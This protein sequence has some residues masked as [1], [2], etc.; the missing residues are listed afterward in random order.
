MTAIKGFIGGHNEAYSRAVSKAVCINL[1][2]EVSASDSDTTA[3]AL[4]KIPGTTSI[5]TWDA[6]GFSGEANAGCRGSYVT[7]RGVQYSCLGDLIL[8]YPDIDSAP[9][10]VANIP[11]DTTPVN[12]AE[13]GIYLAIAD[14]NALYIVELST[15]ATSTPSLPTYV[16]PTHIAFLGGRLVINSKTAVGIGSIGVAPVDSK[17]YYSAVYDATKWLSDGAGSKAVVSSSDP[18]VAIVAINDQILA[19]GSNSV[20]FLGLTDSETIPLER[21]SG[22]TNGSGCLARYSPL[23]IGQS[24]YFVGVQANGMVQVYRTNGYAIEPISDPSIEWILSQGDASDAVGWTY[25]QQGHTFYG[26]NSQNL[27]LTL[28]YDITTGAWHKRSTRVGDNDK[29]W[30][31]TSFT[32]LN[33][34]V[35]AFSKSDALVYRI[36]LDL[37]KEH[38][39]YIYWQRGTGILQDELNGIV[40]NRITLHMETGTGDSAEPTEKDP[41]VSLSWSDDANVNFTATDTENIGNDGAG[42]RKIDFWRAGYARQRSYL[43]SGWHPVKIVLLGAYVNTSLTGR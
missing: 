9:V 10:I 20:E 23:V 30:K 11:Y 22:S 43:I 32:S 5:A 2:P 4:I 15:Y 14:G 36:G 41:T 26:I 40:H 13:N 31:Y 27:D 37:Y 35:Y 7:S 34:V 28:V 21:V 16:K 8:R 19:L 6:T 29:Q 17:L 18:C 33:G 12:F 39:Q 25:S 24:C 3:G 42:G 38:D 1:Y